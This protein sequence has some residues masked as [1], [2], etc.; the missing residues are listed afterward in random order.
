MSSQ[1]TVSASEVLPKIL[2]GLAPHDTLSFEELASAY[3]YNQTSDRR[4]LFVRLVLDEIRRR[5]GPARVLD[6]GCGSGIGSGPQVK[7]DYLR[8][9]RGEA[10]ELWGIEP[11]EGMMPEPGI[12]DRFEH[13]TLEGADLPADSVDV[14]YSFFVMEHVDDPSAFLTSLYRCLKPGGTYLFVTPNRRHLF[15][16]LAKTMKAM[17]IDEVVLKMVRGKMVDAYHYP[18]RYRINDPEAI[19]RH[20]ADVGFNPPEFG[21][22]ESYSMTSYFRGPLRPMLWALSAKRKLIRNPRCLLN[23]VCR[24][25]K[26]AGG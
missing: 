7:L 24:M 21:F 1:V 13:A 23:L 18:V 16:I 22:F 12:M 2:R 9:V 6:I 26:P 10:D 11:D 19:G 17:H 5:P 15:T 3:S 14:A 25:T 8:A 20:A 4:R